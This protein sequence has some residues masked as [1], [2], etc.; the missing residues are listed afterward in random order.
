[1]KLTEGA[2]NIKYSSKLKLMF[3]FDF[4]DQYNENKN[5]LIHIKSVSYVN[6]VFL[7]VSEM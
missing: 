2:D 1:M 5:M 4:H 7:S 3:F 6:S